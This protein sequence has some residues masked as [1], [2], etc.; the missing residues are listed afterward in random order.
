MYGWLAI[1]RSTVVQRFVYVCVRCTQ[2][3]HDSYDAA[4]IGTTMIQDWVRQRCGCILCVRSRH[5]LLVKRH[6]VTAVLN[7]FRAVVPGLFDLEARVHVAGFTI[8]PRSHGRLSHRR[9]IIKIRLLFQ[10][11]G[12]RV[13]RA[14]RTVNIITGFGSTRRL[15]RPCLA[16]AT[17]LG[18]ALSFVFL[19]FRVRVLRNHLRCMLGTMTSKVRSVLRTCSIRISVRLRSPRRRDWACRYLRRHRL[20]PGYAATRR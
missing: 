13:F 20:G 7:I 15:G 1:Q 18:T 11:A 8:I 17:M 10:S 4:G 12:V 14:V 19:L 2:Y 6:R 9:L 5:S 3:L 16:T